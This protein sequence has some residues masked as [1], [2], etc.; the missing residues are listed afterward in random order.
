M[1][2]PARHPAESLRH[3]SEAS[4][5]DIAA[6]CASRFEHASRVFI[7]LCVLN[8]AVSLSW[9][10]VFPTAARVLY[11]WSLL[12]V[13]GRFILLR[14]FIFFFPEGL[15]SFCTHGLYMHVISSSQASRRSCSPARTRT[16]SREGFPSVFSVFDGPNRDSQYSYASILIGVTAGLPVPACSSC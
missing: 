4:C 6:Y 2:G 11:L 5:A 8:R 3:F 15:I 1:R 10:A 7:G 16:V 9:S 13:F 12:R 14:E